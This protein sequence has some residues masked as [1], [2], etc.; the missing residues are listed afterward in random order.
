MVVSVSSFMARVQRNLE[1]AD[2]ARGPA[3]GLDRLPATAPPAF[4]PCRK[5]RHSSREVKKASSRRPPLTLRAQGLR[6]DRSPGQG[7]PSRPR[8]ARP[9]QQTETT[10]ATIGTFTRIGQRLHRLGQDPD[11]Q[12]QG[13]VRPDRQGQRQGARLSHLRRHHRVR[14]RL[15]EDRPRERSRV[16]LGQA[17]RSELPGADLRLAGRGRGRREL[18]PDLV[19]PQR[20][21][22]PARSRA[23]PLRRR[24]FFASHDR[25]ARKQG[26]GIGLVCTGR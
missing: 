4:F 15:E 10:M 12:R 21:L 13:Q 7:S 2:Q 6:A 8:W 26:A 14:R 24:G 23:P 17:R 25:S 18:Q 1:W 20:R 19:P 9:E 3:K 16:S 22:I 11:A 5:G